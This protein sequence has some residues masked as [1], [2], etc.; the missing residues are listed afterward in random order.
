MGL[1]MKRT[2]DELQFEE[3]NV[4]GADKV[5]AVLREFF[6]MIVM[7]VALALFCGKVLIVNANIPSGSMENTIHPG[8]RVIGS[9]LAYLGKEPQREDIIIFRFPDDESQI[10][11]KRVIGLPGEQ[12]QIV[13]GQVYID[14]AK[15]P[16][17]EG[18]LKESPQ[19]SFGPYEVPEDSYF[20]MG[21]N[22]NNS[23]DSR[24]WEDHF[25]DR[26]EIMAK[27]WFQYY[28][29]IGLVD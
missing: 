27:A 21:D 12:V 6:Q 13:D 18:Y 9:R 4:Q 23:H 14:G 29:R 16:L 5:K 1:F 11:I 17:E 19:G 7:P 15:T 10:F 22:R 20:V 26:D 28:P 3:D 25:V 2:E 8:D 24:F